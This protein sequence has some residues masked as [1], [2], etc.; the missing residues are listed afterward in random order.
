MKIMHGSLSA[1]LTEVKEQGKVDGL[2]VAALVQSTLTPTMTAP[3]Y[4]SWIVVAAALGGGAWAELRMLVGRQRAELTE[5]SYP[6]PSRLT[7]LTEERLAEVRGWIEATG[8]AMAPGIL[9]HDA[10]SVDGVLE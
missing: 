7:Q 9:A 5:R 8:L 3:L 6:V 2:R 10:E 1:L 4:A